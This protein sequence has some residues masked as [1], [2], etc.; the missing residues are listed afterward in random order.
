LILTIIQVNIRA[1]DDSGNGR[2][3]P[4]TS[5][6]IAFINMRGE[7]Y[8]DTESFSTDFTGI[9]NYPYLLTI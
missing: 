4:Q 5:V 2:S 6:V 7:P 1:T 9:T 8:F 3:S